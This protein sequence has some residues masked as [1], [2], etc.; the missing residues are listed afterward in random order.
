MGAFSADGEYFLT[1]P[2]KKNRFVPDMAADRASFLKIRGGH[3]FGEVWTGR[4]VAVCRH[5]VL[6][7]IERIASLSATSPLRLA[8]PMAGAGFAE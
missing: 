3:A 5:V 2:G 7:P 4:L 1:D 8:V 6:V